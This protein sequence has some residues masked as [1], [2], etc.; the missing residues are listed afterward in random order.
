MSLIKTNFPNWHGLTDFFDDHWLKERFTGHWMPAVNIIDN[1]KD[2]EVEVVAPG[3]KKEDFDVAIENGV[4]TIIGKTQKEA[5][6]KEKKFTRHEFSYRSFTK[7]FT[8]PENID[9]DSIKA[10]YEEGVLKLMLN[11]TAIKLPPKKLVEIL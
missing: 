2:Y 8:L 7:R 9:P 3:L 6:E 1:E 11:K 4:I 10:K 5:E